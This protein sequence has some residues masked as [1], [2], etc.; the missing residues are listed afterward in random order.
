[1]GGKNVHFFLWGS[2]R[3]GRSTNLRWYVMDTSATLMT[4]GE[5]SNYI[6]IKEKTIYSKVAAKQIPY[7]R[8]GGLIRFKKDEIDQW[9][10]TQRV[11]V[12]SDRPTG[13]TRAKSKAAKATADRIVRKIIDEE[14]DKY[15]S[16]EYGK[17]DRIEGHRKEVNNGSI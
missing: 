4:I 5:C 16:T 8:I 14:T 12:C 6:N 17:S 15:Y 2:A 11:G 1:M 9:I 13:K 3:V 10:L 7:Y